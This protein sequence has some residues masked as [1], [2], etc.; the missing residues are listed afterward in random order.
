M[1][2]EM[3]S[4]S[5][6]LLLS[7]LALATFLTVTAVLTAPNGVSGQANVP[8]I[9]SVDFTGN[10]AFADE[11]LQRRIRTRPSRC[12]SIVLQFPLIFCPLGFDFAHENRFLNRR[13]TLPDDVS[14]LRI[15]YYLRGFREATVDTVVTDRGSP[16]AP[17][18]DVSFSIQENRPTLVDSLEIGWPDG[19]PMPEIMGELRTKLGEP[20]DG[21]ALTTDL[22]SI[23]ARFRN[24]GF[25]HVEVLRSYFIPSG[26]YEAEVRFDIYPGT[27][28]RVGPITV[29]GNR[30]VDAEVVHRLLP[31]EEGNRYRAR[32]VE[33]A[34]RNLFSLDV[35]RA[36]NIQPDTAH[37]PDSVVPIRVEVAE[38]PLIRGRWGG[39]LSTADCLSAEA[40]ATHRNFAGG[41]RRLQLTGRMSNILANSLNG[42]VCDAVEDAVFTKLDWFVSADFTQPWII[43]PRN[44]LTASLFYERQSLKDVFIRK[45]VGADVAI[46]RTIGRTSILSLGYRPQRT[47]LDAAELFF[48]SSFLV[49]EPED[50]SV[51]QGAN[52]L[53]PGVLTLTSSRIDQLLNPSRGWSLR[54]ELEAAGSTTASDFAYRRWVSDGAAYKQLSPGWV[55]A[56][57]VRA[58][59]VH[60]A[61]FAG[62]SATVNDGR[63]IIHPQKRFFAGGANTVRG[64]SQNQLGPRVLAVEVGRLVRARGENGGGMPVCQPEEIVDFSCDASLLNLGGELPRPTGGSALL[65]ANAELR[66]PLGQDAFQG[67][68]FMDVGQVWSE[69][70]DISPSSL[71]WTPGLGLRYFSPIG[72]VRVDLGYRLADTQHLR[73][74]TQQL[75]P[76]D[77]LRDADSDRIEVRSGEFLDFVQSSEL[78]VLTPAVPFDDLDAFSFRRLQFHLSI[79]Q[80]F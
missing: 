18:V 21:E 3:P 7:H 48:C 60:A 78:A 41:A 15:F 61:E 6:R 63:T 37:R 30:E 5:G 62:L 23:Q 50:I 51:L 22:D 26:A 42:S 46:N 53:A 73:V 55:L 28:A 2:I 72:P 9:K 79:G 47:S 77:P 80:A 39:G 13:R 52:W 27:R 8:K 45:G 1:M 34:R 40:T 74:V 59:S 14:R 25:A 69:G 24:E 76:F 66:F 54:V 20:L 29:A 49:C 58:G 43:S 70:S 33:D 10:Q 56:T 67:A 4:R 71:E 11:E 17:A 64:Y 32:L 75:R 65:V 16:A 68:A 12:K 57:R 19:Q 36:A 44:T 35:F 31:F 38:G